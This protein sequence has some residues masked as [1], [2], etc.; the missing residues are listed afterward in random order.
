[1]IH[2]FGWFEAI[3]IMF[4]KFGLGAKVAGAKT[5]AHAITKAGGQKAIATATAGMLAKRHIIDLFSQFF[6]EHSV[7]KYKNNLIDVFKMKYKEIQK[8][9]LAQRVRA[10]GSTLLSVPLL[11][12]FWTKVLSTA[13]QKILYALLFPLFSMLWN[14]ITA[15]LNVITFIF[16]ILM[17]NILVETLA[18]YRL[19]KMFLNFIDTIVSLIF[20]SF[21]L[22][23]R[24]LG[25]F[26]LNP[27]SWLIK[28]SLKFNSWLE[29]ILDK[30]LNHMSKVQ[31]RRDRYV[32]TI[33]SL[34]EKRYVYT[35]NRKDRRVS[36]YKHIKKL[37]S[38]NI[39]K[40]K[41]WREMRVYKIELQRKKYNAS[42]IK[43]RKESVSKKRERKPLL[44]PYRSIYS[45]RK[46]VYIFR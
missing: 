20:K 10:F 15:G 7:K 43:R 14:F 44:L 31:N 25:L 21:K 1:M 26:G 9:S 16:K 39:L 34:S 45:C 36:F 19:G 17:L 33:E 24:F 22:F 37:F 5:F 41:D 35:Q 38:Q 23:N 40:K 12:F 3:G 46:K 28:I 32:N 4:L 18:E 13:I 6:S 11:Y 30:H 29:K 27:K 2:Y 8:S 42:S